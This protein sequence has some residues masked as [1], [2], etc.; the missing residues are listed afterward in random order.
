MLTAPLILDSPSDP[1]HA[2]T[3]IDIQPDSGMD[4]SW[5][6]GLLYR[7]PGLLPAAH[8]DSSYAPLLALGREVPTARGPIDNL[9]VS[10]EGI[11][12]VVETKLWKNP[13]KHRTVVAQILDYAKELKGWSYDTL[14][15]AVLSSSR[16][17]KETEQPSLEDR[18][19]PALA[20]ASLEL[21][22]FQE[23]V[24]K[25]LAT[26]NM[27]LLIVG[28]RVS[29]NVALMSDAVQGAPGFDFT[30]GLIEMQMYATTGS[31]PW[32]LFVVSDVAG[33][34][35]EKTRGVIRVV[36]EQSKP[37]VLVEPLNEASLENTETIDWGLFLS[38]VPTDLK[39]AYEK[40]HEDWESVGRIWC[41]KSR[42]YFA[43]DIGDSTHRFVQTKEGYIELYAR[44]YFNKIEG[45]DSSIYEQYEKRL[46]ASVPAAK[47][48]YAHKVRI[49]W[50]DLSVD[51][52]SVVFDAAI[53][54]ARAVQGALR[55]LFVNKDR[56]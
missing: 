51:D 36:Y 49:P 44:S 7:H 56:V 24:V 28:D 4:E 16:R 9:Y 30:I 21:A 42:I 29:P 53:E 26:G 2:L 39:P 35:V 41:S 50:R 10:P 25:N 47:T 3:R 34:T 45:L 27:L 55:K 14:A 12:T 48:L 54:L 8:F 43:V 52:L 5:L 38:S 31:A 40:A 22:D 1:G 20:A 15:A 13:G 46:Q 17:M 6:Q 19:K 18:V 33:K 37:E 11:I 32:P 23:A